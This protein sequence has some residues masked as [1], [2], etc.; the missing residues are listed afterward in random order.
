M[1]EVEVIAKQATRIFDLESQVDD[2][3]KRM[4]RI[5][6]H[7]VCIGGPL[8]DNVLGWSVEAGR[9]VLRVRFSCQQFA[10]FV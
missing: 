4:K 7:C 5:V 2:L 10:L 8:N 1:T 9:G 6:L 3:T